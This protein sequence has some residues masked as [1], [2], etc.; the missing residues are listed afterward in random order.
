MGLDVYFMVL[1]PVNNAQNKV[2]YK[3]L[4]WQDDDIVVYEENSEDEDNSDLIL[5][6][7]DGFHLL[8]F[9][10]P[11]PL[12]YFLAGVAGPLSITPD[13]DIRKSGPHITSRRFEGKGCSGLPKETDPVVGLVLSPKKDNC[14]SFLVSD[15]LK[16]S[17]DSV[18]T[19]RDDKEYNLK[20]YQPTKDLLE[21]LTRID[22][23]W[24]GGIL[25]VIL[26]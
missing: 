19:D 5:D 25:V 8:G 17:F 7:C 9:Y 6:R 14:V 4:H 3:P 11:Y 20:D 16:D 26:V 23:D 15:I 18:Y 22:K 12:S 24:K 13:G 21:F 1:V 2:T 10:K